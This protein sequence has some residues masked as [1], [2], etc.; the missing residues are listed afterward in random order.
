LENFNRQGRD[1]RKVK[2]SSYFYSKKTHRLIEKKILLQLD[3]EKLCVRRV[4]GGK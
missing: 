4:L 1:G 2:K 3:S